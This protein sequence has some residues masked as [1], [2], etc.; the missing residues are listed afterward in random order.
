ME[1]GG[2]DGGAL[3]RKAGRADASCAVAVG[4]IS[5]TSGGKDTS[6]ARVRSHSGETAEYLRVNIQDVYDAPCPRGADPRS[7]P[8]GA[9]IG[10]SAPFRVEWLRSILRGVGNCCSTAVNAI[11]RSPR[12]LATPAAF[13]LA[14]A[15]K[16]GQSVGGLHGVVVFRLTT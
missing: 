9:E 8:R 6:P 4:P 10:V 13:G 14:K 15:R 12:L 7:I 3:I 5:G 11:E 2:T 1:I 16:Q